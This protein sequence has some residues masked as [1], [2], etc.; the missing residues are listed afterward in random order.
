MPGPVV[1]IFASPVADTPPPSD[2]SALDSVPWSDDPLTD[3]VRVSSAAARVGFDW[4]SVPPVVAAV[5]RELVELEEAVASDDAS[6]LRHEVGDV[7]LAVCNVAR[8]LGV[9]PAE[10]L[11]DANHRFEQRFRALE[12]RAK[13][14]GHALTDLDDEELERRW[15]QAKRALASQENGGGASPRA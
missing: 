8:H 15:Q 7:L 3:A 1:S 11:R 6:A 5:R 2:R 14:D 13:G 4:R 12:A 10:A 9:S